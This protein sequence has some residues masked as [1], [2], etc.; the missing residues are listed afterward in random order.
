MNET[1]IVDDKESTKV[2][3]GPGNQLQ[4]ARILKGLSIEDVASRMHLSLAILQAIEENNFSDRAPIFVKGYIRAYARLVSLDEDELV[5]CYVELYADNDPP[6][7]ATSSIR[8][9]ISSHSASI[10]W[11]NYLVIIVLIALLSAWWWNKIQNNSESES[12][13]LDSETLSDI[14]ITEQNNEFET[15]VVF[16]EPA[17]VVDESSLEPLLEPLPE[18]DATVDDIPVGKTLI[19]DTS[20]DL[21]QQKIDPIDVKPIAVAPIPVEPDVISEVIASADT[22]KT[23]D[24]L[25]K[26]VAQLFDASYIAPTGVDLLNIIVKAD[27]WADIKDVN[28]HQLVYDLLRAN[29]SIQIRG[30]APFNAFFGNGRGVEVTF[31]DQPI[32]IASRASDDNTARLT[33]GTN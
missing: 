26:T 27:T 30:E 32:D 9:E 13:L 6:I 12:V 2:N 23:D 3:N 18:T 5:K 19:E 11:T 16:E 7:N 28:N 17:A 14:A 10:K 31:N 22:S 20:V 25:D 4:A 24:T 29:R 1:E 15:I 8:A 21:T 33:I